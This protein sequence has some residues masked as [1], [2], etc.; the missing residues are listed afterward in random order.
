[1]EGSKKSSSFY[2]LLLG[3]VG[4]IAAALIAFVTVGFYA[5]EIA[6]SG[7]DNIANSEAR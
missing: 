7:N 1:M 6:G 5:T 2:G 4:I 3:F